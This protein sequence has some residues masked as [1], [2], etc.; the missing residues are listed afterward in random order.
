MTLTSP[1]FL[2]GCVLGLGALLYGAAVLG[3]WQLH[4]PGMALAFIGYVVGNIG[5]IIDAIGAAK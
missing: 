1:A 5:L 4:R 3:Y 2:V